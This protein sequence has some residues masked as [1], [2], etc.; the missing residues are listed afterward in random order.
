MFSRRTFALEKKFRSRKDAQLPSTSGPTPTHSS[1][2]TKRAR[3]KSS[4]RRKKASN[5][6]REVC[7]AARQ[8]TASGFWAS[9]AATVSAA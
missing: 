4:P 3:E 9:S 8:S 6:G 7:P 5:T 2:P 1:R